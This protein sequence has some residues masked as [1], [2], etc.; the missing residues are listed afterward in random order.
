MEVN[1][2]DSSGACDA[3]G[4]PSE[5]AIPGMPDSLPPPATPEPADGTDGDANDGSLSPAGMVRILSAVH[6]EVGLTLLDAVQ[7]LAVPGITSAKWKFLGCKDRG[8]WI[9]MTPADFA[10]TMLADFGPEY[11]VKVGLFEC[12]GDDVR[13]VESLN[14]GAPVC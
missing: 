6:S 11:L 12:V 7:N 10:D 3:G 8:Q 4:S 9:D 14:R 1:P 5:T 13:L 2:A